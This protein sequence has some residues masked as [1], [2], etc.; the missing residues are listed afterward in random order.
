MRALADVLYLAAI[1][2]L[3]FLIVWQD[4]EMRKMTMP[5]CGGETRGMLVPFDPSVDGYAW[6]CLNVGGSQKNS[7]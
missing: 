7:N 2:L 1:A 4:H 6:V 5:A 3:L